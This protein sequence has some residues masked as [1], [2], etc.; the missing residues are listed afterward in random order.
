M[1]CRE[2]KTIF[3]MIEIYERIFHKWECEY[4]LGNITKK[5]FVEDI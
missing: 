3:L 5:Q 2:T 4:L 1:L